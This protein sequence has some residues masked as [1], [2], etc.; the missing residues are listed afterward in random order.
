MVLGVRGPPRGGGGPHR[1]E[2]G[3]DA[4]SVRIGG[5]LLEELLQREAVPADGEEGRVGHCDGKGHRNA[6][7]RVGDDQF[8]V[9]HCV[10]V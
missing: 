7:F 10:E 2:Q 5:E 4:G 6:R 8:L 9:R 1:V 3:V